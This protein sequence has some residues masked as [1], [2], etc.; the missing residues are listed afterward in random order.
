MFSS[1]S[2]HLLPRRVSPTQLELGYGSWLGLGLGLLVNFS[3]TVFFNY[4]SKRI[5]YFQLNEESQ[6]ILFL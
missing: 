3:K 2:G 5:I 4:I 6:I 1:V